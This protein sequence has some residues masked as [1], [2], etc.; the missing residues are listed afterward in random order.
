MALMR[1]VL[2]GLLLIGVAACGKSETP[3]AAPAPAA[4][5]AARGGGAGGAAP[6]S[7]AQVTEREMPVTVHAVGTAAASSTVDIRSQ[8]TGVLLKVGFS[9][10]Q[11]VKAGEVLFT[12][13]ARP[14][15]ATLDQ[16]M[17][18]LSR[19]RAQSMNADE[20]LRRSEELLSKGLVP[21][22]DRD[23]LA[24]N[25]AALRGTLAADTAAV[26]NARLQLQFTKITAPVSGRT[27][28]LISHEGALVRAN[29]T[30]PLVTISQ[31]APVLVAFA[32]PARLLPKLRAAKDQGTLKVQASVPG[33]PESAATGTISFID[34]SVDPST[35]TI[36]IKGT[37]PNTDRMIWPGQYV[38]VSLQLAV[39]PHAIV[40][41][42]AALQSGQQGQ[43]V[44]VV[45]S[46]KT[47][48][49]RPVR[50]AW[51]EGATTVIESGLTTDDQVVTDGQLRLTP[52]AK[53]T[54]KPAVGA[55]ESPAAGR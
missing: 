16:A 18:V 19:D 36:K 28:A 22:A 42:T 14:F 51:T 31:T 45:R 9:E 30:T 17:A 35:D 34:A 4:G 32:M 40:I 37:F 8:V 55:K 7:V 48:D 47:V 15:Q 21:K 6:V 12:L 27:G 38:D 5:A 10:G 26:E 52:G 54:V 25:A 3:A 20:L 29:D 1:S 33:V 41:P 49:M 39:E 50:V 11:D 53:I 2:I 43:F 46:D 24:A 13:D 23:T 44:Y